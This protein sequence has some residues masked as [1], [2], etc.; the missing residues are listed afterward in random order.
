[1]MSAPA[2]VGMTAWRARV[3]MGAAGSVLASDGS[4]HSLEFVWEQTHTS[5]ITAMFGGRGPDCGAI[6][7]PPAPDGDDQKDEHRSEDD[8]IGRFRSRY[9]LMT[10][11]DTLPDER[12]HEVSH[13]AVDI[14]QRSPSPA[15][16]VT[17][18]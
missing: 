1:M 10:R 17:K 12:A 7:S 16:C 6:S 13:A 11:A 14:S 2:A 3:S 15:G 18:V 9:G 8:E 4:Q 5:V